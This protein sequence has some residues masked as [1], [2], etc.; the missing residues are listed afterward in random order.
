MTLG[1][2]YANPGLP[3]EY[4]LDSDPTV[5]AGWG[6]TNAEAGSIL[7]RTDL[8]SIYRKTGPNPTD[9]TLQASASSAG[10]NI[11]NTGVA[12]AGN[13]HSVLNFLSGVFGSDAGG[14][15]ADIQMI[16]N[17]TQ[18][19]RALNTPFQP[20]LTRPV[21]CIYSVEIAAG[22]G[23][24]SPGANG[25]VDLCSDPFNPPTTVRCKVVNDMAGQISPVGDFLVLRPTLI[26][27]FLAP[28]TWWVSME[29]D[30]TGGGPS[31]ALVAVSEIIL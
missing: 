7:Y 14:G 22:F 26:L 27:V 24:G 2:R 3:V 9:W 5:F 21:L 29:T 4:D 13:P 15:V 1:I 12:I 23:N 11:Q 19:V 18:P 30:S 31:F 25:S 20:S 28:P 16:P 6:G 8:P 10:V 17:P